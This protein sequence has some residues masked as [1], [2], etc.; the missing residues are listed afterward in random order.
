VNLINILRDAE[1]VPE[2]LQGNCSP[3][4]L[5][6]ALVT[7]LADETVRARQCEAFAK[8]TASL[9]PSSGPPSRL[10]ARTVLALI[11]R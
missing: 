8:A 1:I 11:G 9:S 6:Q 4:A 7:L 3:D 5:T 10:A 2:L